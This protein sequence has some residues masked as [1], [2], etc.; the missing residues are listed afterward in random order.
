MREMLNWIQEIPQRHSASA[1][2]GWETDLDALGTLSGADWVELYRYSGRGLFIPIRSKEILFKDAVPEF[3][4]AMETGKP[5][6][7]EQRA[8]LPLLSGADPLGVLLLKFRDI[9]PD[10][11]PDAVLAGVG[12]LAL[13]LENSQKQR[14][15]D[16]TAQTSQGLGEC[17]DRDELAE[18]LATFLLNQ[19]Q[20]LA[21]FELEYDSYR[22][23]WYVRVSTNAATS[24]DPIS[25]LPNEEAHAVLDLLEEQEAFIVSDLSKLGSTLQNWFN[26]Q[27]TQSVYV[28]RLQTRSQLH[29]F[30]CAYDRA[31]QIELSAAEHSMY[32]NMAQQV[33]ITLENLNLNE[34]LRRRT[35][36]SALQAVAL[37]EINGLVD[38][39]E[40]LSERELFDEGAR[41]LHAVA[42]ADHAGF[43]LLD[44]DGKMA[45][46]VG[47]YPDA[48]S[49]GMKVDGGG[50][51]VEIMKRER[52]PLL[53][54][55]P[56]NDERLQQDGKALLRSLGIESAVFVPLFGI[57]QQFMGS[58]GLDYYKPRHE[59][60][61][62]LLQLVMSICNQIIATYQRTHLQRSAAR[63][64]QQLREIAAYSQSVLG[65]LDRAE[66]LE[67][68]L[69]AVTRALPVDWINILL[70]DPR[71]QRLRLVAWQD[72]NGEQIN[73]DGPVL[74]PGSNSVAE[75]AWIRRQSLTIQNL[76]AEDWSHPQREQ[77]HGIICQ[78][79]I[80]PDG[81]LGLLEL[82]QRSAAYTDT[83]QTV[84][85]QIGNLLALALTNA[86]TLEQTQRSAANKERL[87]EIV[88][89]L[90][91]QSDLEDVLSVTAAQV[92]RTLGAKRARIHIGFQGERPAVSGVEE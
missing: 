63:Q 74:V 37:Q 79:L 59:V 57:N 81:A 33:A 22:K 49:V 19:E 47:D 61:S 92:G 58:F 12:V 66:I 16:L 24:G 30:L 91:R 38:R 14:M 51:T 67:T 71:E 20:A 5:V 70:H 18:L 32:A 13:A 4:Q 21:L 54:L 7:I 83:D 25:T 50:V 3:M 8:I 75:E 29:G 82:G 77:L 73:P 60:D 27:G 85:R 72:E 68:T 65:S 39:M 2:E 41:I 28:V 86:R 9:A 42:E 56:Q 78:P 55:D 44:P 88:A 87:N 46:V 1:R 89:Q 53:L 10:P 48:G 17:R 34:E 6:S 36:Q 84:V 26:A 45:T 52:A 76:S 11:I 64:T 40:T 43:V 62:T 90:Q 23:K 15:L 80:A 31:H 35:E 69:V